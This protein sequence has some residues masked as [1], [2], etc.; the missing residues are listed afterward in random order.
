MK[1]IVIGANGQLGSD[2]AHVF[3]TGGFQVLAMTHG[4]IEV[5]Q[6]DSVKRVLTTFQP[7]I[8]LNTAA[9]H[10]VPQCEKEPDRAYAVNSLGALNIARVC[11]EIGASTIYFSTD[12][13]F[14]GLKGQPYI[15]E[16][17][18][19]PLN[20][21]AMTKLAGEYFTLNYCTGGTVARVSGIY[22]EVPCR[23]KGGNFITTMLKLARE[24]PE[25]RVVNDEILTP[26]PTREIA[27][28]T[29]ELAR[30]GLRGLFHLTCE[31]ECSWYE[32]AEVIFEERRLTTPLSPCSAAEMPPSV[33]R[34]SYSV[35]EN[36]RL[37][38]SGLSPMPHWKE[39]LV[40]F[41][42]DT[43]AP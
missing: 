5:E 23:A 26:T 33:Q 7:E 14:D 13:V 19:N 18:P 28:K 15:E 35:L 4:D 32:F 27:K 37:A 12:Y 41:L 16:D 36:G 11:E 39:A 30:G 42:R 1:A 9:Y 17:K 24:K 38:A 8:V 34:P 10:V 21:Y 22:G 29:L 6:V 40:S 2:L 25:V 3:R 31:G 43:A 20:V